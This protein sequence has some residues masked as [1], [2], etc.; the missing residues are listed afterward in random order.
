[1]LIKEK[2]ILKIGIGA[3][4][5]NNI[6]NPDAFEGYHHQSIDNTAC[7]GHNKHQLDD[8]ETGLS[9]VRPENV[10]IWDLLSYLIISQHQSIVRRSRFQVHNMPDYVEE[11]HQKDEDE[12]TGDH[13]TH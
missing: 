4:V 13:H 7:H 12:S 6:L 8:E 10:Q 5:L 1:M 3:L 9:L 11:P 2:D